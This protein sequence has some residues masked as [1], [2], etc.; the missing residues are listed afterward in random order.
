MERLPWVDVTYCKYGTP[1]RKQTRLWTNMRW[2][3][4]RSLRP[5][6]RCEAWQDGR[7]L[8][9][10]AGAAAD[11]GAAL[12]RS[13]C[14]VRGDCARGHGGAC[15]AAEHSGLS[16]RPSS[17]PRG[18]EEAHFSMFLHGFLAVSLNI[19]N[20]E[21]GHRASFLVFWA[22]SKAVS[23]FIKN[24]EEGH[25]AFFL[26]FLLNFKSGHAASKMKHTGP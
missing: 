14:A 13:C 11:G 25:R 21:E 12:Q 18:L 1:Y 15:G 23:R 4:R 7:H 9:A 24:D 19:K 3:P 2:R 8:R 20:D 5:G 22:H 10:A 26:P 17:N 6:S 16:P